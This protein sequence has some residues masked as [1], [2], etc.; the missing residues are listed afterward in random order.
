MVLWVVCRVL[1]TFRNLGMRYLDNLTFLGIWHSL[2][3]SSPGTFSKYYAGV[4][5][6]LNFGRLWGAVSKGDRQE[7]CTPVCEVE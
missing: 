5:L 6:V 4:L 2:S 1:D 3:T 7:D